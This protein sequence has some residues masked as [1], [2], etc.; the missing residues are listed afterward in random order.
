[1]LHDWI[2]CC[3]VA[4]SYTYLGYG[5]EQFDRATFTRP[6]GASQV[7]SVERL[8]VLC[9]AFMGACT[10]KTPIRDWSQVLSESR[11]GYDGEVVA[12]AQ[13]ITVEQ[14][15]PALPPEGIGG[16]VDSLE[17]CDDALRPL[18]EDPSISIR[19][20]SEWPKKLTKARMRIKPDEW[21]KLAPILFKRGICTTLRPDELIEHN[22]DKLVNGLLGVGKKK[23]ITSEATAR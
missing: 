12:K 10:A 1:M 7:A 8:H 19:P 22:G 14:V 5:T 11:I 3:T 16:S 17:L 4:I 23:W 9:D 15:L 18:L 13:E 6:V 21:L 20:R 2:F